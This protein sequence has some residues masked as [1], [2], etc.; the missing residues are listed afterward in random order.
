[1]MTASLTKVIEE[2]TAKAKVEHELM[3]QI[4]NAIKWATTPERREALQVVYDFAFAAG[5][6]ETLVR[7][8]RA[9]A[10]LAAGKS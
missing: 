7:N 5:D 4:E 2:A 1:M 3:E 10:T 6:D 9:V 8:L